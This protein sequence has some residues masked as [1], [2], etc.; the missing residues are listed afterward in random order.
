MKYQTFLTYDCST[1]AN[2]KQWAQGIGTALTALGWTKSSDPGQVTWAN[3]VTV[4]QRIPQ[5]NN[6]TFNGAWVGGTAYTGLSVASIGNVQ[7][8]TNGGLT[9]ACILSTQQ[10]L[11]ATTTVIQNTAQTLTLSAVAAASGGSTGYT[12]TITGGAANAFAGFVFVITGF[13]NANNNGT[14][15]CLTSTVTVLTLSNAFGT[16]VTAAG[17]ATSSANNTGYFANATVA[18]WASNGVINHSYTMTGF[19]GGNAADN[20]TFTV[21]ASH[22]TNS[23][24][25]V[26]MLGVANAS[27]VT[28]NQASAFATEN[29]IPSLDLV[30]WTPYNYEVWQMTDAS[31]ATSPILMRFVYATNSLL[32][33]NINF[34]IST[35]FSNAWPTGNTFSSAA[36]YQETIVTSSNNPGGPT[37]YE[38]NFCVDV[39]G[40][41][42]SM[43]L[44]RPNGNGACIL[45]LD[46][47]KDNFGTSID[48]FTTVCFATNGQNTS[49]QQLLFK[50]GNGGVIP[51][52]AQQ[53]NIGWC[54]VAATGST[55]AYNGMAPVLPV[56]P[57]PPGY[58]ASPLLGCV[59]MKQNDTAE[60]TLQSAYMYGAIHTFL[61]SRNFQRTDP[62][63]QTTGAAGI[64][65]E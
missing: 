24:T 13:A 42:L 18:T 20:G 31:A 43:M 53:L 2:Y 21:L 9:F 50:P 61:M 39:A 44:W 17:T 35:S 15:I 63:V 22:N 8:V 52:G 10:A 40:G 27:G 41:S 11:A 46:R 56:F 55:L 59:F 64:R 32:I 23:L 65:W 36:V 12:G 45:V 25:S 51:A 7:A 60:G 5:A 58:L 48:S 28:T 37:L 26:G 54:T 33:P 62:V 57:N 29:T 4:P 49:G 34:I 1:V 14:F 47:A 19:G 6:F 30:H 38:S 16:A 3:V